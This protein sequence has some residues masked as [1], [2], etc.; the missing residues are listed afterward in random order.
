[1]K[2]LGLQQLTGDAGLDLEL[3]NRVVSSPQPRI[4]VTR[5]RKMG[6]RQI[7][8]PSARTRSEERRR[9]PNLDGPKTAQAIMLTPSA[10]GPRNLNAR[11]SEM[12]RTSQDSKK[13]I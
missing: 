12:P 7:S 3:P 4:S 11:T 1:M 2:A 5:K 9:A 10:N 13:L 8:T 6:V